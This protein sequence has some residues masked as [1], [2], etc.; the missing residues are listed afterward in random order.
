[1]LCV[2][3]VFAMVDETFLQFQK[4]Q[5]VLWLG[6]VVFV[7]LNQHARLQ[8][9]CADNAAHLH[10]IVHFDG[11]DS[12]FVAVRLQ[13][14]DLHVSGTVAWLWLRQHAEDGV[15]WFVGERLDSLRQANDETLVVFGLLHGFVHNV[16]DTAVH[17]DW[18]W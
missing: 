2:P 6:V 17:V 12:V 13:Q 8:L 16:S 7:A 4:L 11:V 5:F 3:V 15:F 14:N 18:F 9:R 1:M 10:R